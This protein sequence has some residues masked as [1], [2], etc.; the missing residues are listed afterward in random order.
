MDQAVRPRI[1]V[2]GPLRIPG[3][4]PVVDRVVERFA[5]SALHLLAR[6][7][8][9]PY[10]VDSSVQDRPDPS[11][12]VRADGVLLLGGG[13][14]DPTLYGVTGPVP[15]LYGVDRAADEHA[16]AVVQEA[17]DTDTPVLGICRGS[18]VV[19][20]ALGGTLVPHIENAQLHRDRERMFLDEEVR[21]A[22]DSRVAAWLGKTHATVRSGHHQAVDE[23]GEGLRPVAWALDGV[24]EGIEHAHAR[25]MGIQWHPEDPDGDPQD[26]LAIFTAFRDFVREAMD[27][28]RPP[29]KTEPTGQ[30]RG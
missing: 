13:D 1:A 30:D 21:L 11:H 26:S 15:E 16:I 8:A 28:G 19:N 24:I 14:I 3:A 7:G 23:P 2:V 6:V 25:V 18:Q 9:D 29:T 10:V 22:P 27:E 20:V 5:T 4:G 12:I 17:L